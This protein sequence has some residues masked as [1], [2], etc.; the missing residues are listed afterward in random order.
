VKARD[1]AAA[2]QID[3]PVVRNAQYD[4][5]KLTVD[6]VLE[7]EKARSEVDREVFLVRNGNG[8]VVRW[9]AP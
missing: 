9:W 3:D 5:L 7:A 2:I 1:V 6:E 8:E 4:R